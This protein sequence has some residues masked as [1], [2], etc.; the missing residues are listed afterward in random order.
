MTM[1]LCKKIL[2][3]RARA[4]SGS[5]AW[6]WWQCSS[7]LCSGGSMDAWAYELKLHPKI[8]AHGQVFFQPSFT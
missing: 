5:G 8:Q 3:M 6:A 4:G 1:G 2:G 7:P